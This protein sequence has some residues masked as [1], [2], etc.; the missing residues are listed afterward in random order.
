MYSAARAVATYLDRS[1]SFSIAR[2]LRSTRKPEVF[3]PGPRV[4]VT[5]ADNR[6]ER[7]WGFAIHKDLPVDLIGC[8]ALGHCSPVLQRLLQGFLSPS[9]LVKANV[10][11]PGIGTEP[12]CEVDG[13]QPDDQVDGCGHEG[14]VT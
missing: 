2:Y 8:P 5:T 4:K 3:L 10:P 9:C 6:S 1:P 13:N 7:P 11:D 14:K 12:P